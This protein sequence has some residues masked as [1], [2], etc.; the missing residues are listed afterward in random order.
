MLAMKPVHAGGMPG[1]SWIGT[2]LALHLGWAACGLPARDAGSPE[3]ETLVA[4]L[5][6]EQITLQEFE[7]YLAAEPDSGQAPASQEPVS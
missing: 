7:A 5:D 4:R 6:E 2:V 1:R 3:R